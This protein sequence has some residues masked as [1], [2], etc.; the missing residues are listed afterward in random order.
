MQT[1]MFEHESVP[2]RNLLIVKLLTMC[3]R[4]SHKQHAVR[5]A[6]EIQQG[7]SYY[8]TFPLLLRTNQITN[9]WI[10]CTKCHNKFYI[11]ACTRTGGNCFACSCILWLHELHTTTR[12]SRTHIFI[13]CGITGNEDNWTLSWIVMMNMWVSLR[14]VDHIHH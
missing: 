1:M 13:T 3:S 6:F 9:G 11:A 5:Q 4:T 2:C 10:Q 7:I 8:R 14:H 12:E